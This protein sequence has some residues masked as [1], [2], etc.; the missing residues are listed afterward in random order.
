MI[1]NKAKNVDI[2]DLA[3]I[4]DTKSYEYFSDID[5]CLGIIFSKHDVLKVVDTAPSTASS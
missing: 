2:S 1:I 4:S 5:A 3:L